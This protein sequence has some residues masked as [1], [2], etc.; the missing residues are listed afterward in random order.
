M[1][2][3][4]KYYHITHSS[5]GLK[6]VKEVK[7]KSPASVS[8]HPCL[9][10]RSSFLWE[11]TG[12]LSRVQTLFPQRHTGGLLGFRP[13]SLGDTQ[14]TCLGFR[15]LWWSLCFDVKSCTYLR[16]ALCN[17]ELGVHS[18]NRTKSTLK[19]CLSRTY[20]TLVLFLFDNMGGMSSYGTHSM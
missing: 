5:E 7:L 8:R 11:H 19:M 18:S 17:C 13:S 4:T 14:V 2:S 16:M 1:P 3:A 12:G 15:S 6:P 10:F 20:T 9:G